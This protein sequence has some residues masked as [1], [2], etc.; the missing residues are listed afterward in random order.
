MIGGLFFVN[1]NL[2]GKYF[3]PN[4]VRVVST[5]PAEQGDIFLP[6]AF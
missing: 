3:D 1:S 6:F 2:S 5:E 4:R